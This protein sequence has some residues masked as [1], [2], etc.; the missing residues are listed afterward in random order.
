MRLEDDDVRTECMD[1][2]SY[3]Q[4]SADKTLVFDSPLSFGT[5]VKTERGVRL[6][7]SRKRTGELIQVPIPGLIGRGAAATAKISGNLVISRKH[8][9]I[10]LDGNRL[11]VLDLG[12]AN[13]TC[14]QGVKIAPYTPVELHDGDE[15]GLASEQ[16][17]VHVSG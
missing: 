5:P 6:S 13:G 15:L 2:S 17:L 11:V 14:V 4:E 12:S 7:L 3:T 1:P 16:F 9:E 10:R 8:A